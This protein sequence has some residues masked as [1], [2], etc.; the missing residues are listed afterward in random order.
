MILFHSYNTPPPIC[1][2]KRLLEACG[3][4]IVLPF[5]NNL[6]MGHAPRMCVSRWQ[7][8][9]V[10][11][12]WFKGYQCEESGSKVQLEVQ[13]QSAASY[14]N[15]RYL[16]ILLLSLVCRLAALLAA[17]S[18]PEMQTPPSHSHLLNI[19]TEIADDG[20]HFKV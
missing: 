16:S 14:P 9:C 11:M 13:Q 18:W 8:V 2:L 6:R 20:M 4:T 5:P 7:Y 17:G 12:W 3:Q 10:C 15:P 1:S 19:L